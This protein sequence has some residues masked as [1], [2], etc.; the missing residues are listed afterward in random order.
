MK[1]GRRDAN[2]AEIRDGL[3]EAGI[4]VWDTADLGGFV[5]LVA[6]GLHRKTFQELTVLFE[7]KTK[8]GKLRPSQVEFIQSWR[9]A[10]H[11][12]RTPAE[13]LAVFGI[14]V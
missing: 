12:V 1:H 3:R 10:I 4:S 6:A 14:K 8:D 5:D 9:G 13:A 11:V 7:V 2:H